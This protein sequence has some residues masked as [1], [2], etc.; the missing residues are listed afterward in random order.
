[1]QAARDFRRVR[2]ISQ[3]EIAGAAAAA[4]HRFFTNF[5]D[6]FEPPR[7]RHGEQAL[8]IEPRDNTAARNKRVVR[9]IA[10]AHEL[11]PAPDPVCCGHCPD[12]SETVRCHRYCPSAA[13]RLSSDQ[14]FPLEPLV[15]PLV[16]E[17]K[18]LGVFYP[19]WSCEGHND[20]E[21]RLNKKP[22]IWFYADSVVHIRALA[23]AIDAMRN[24]GRLALPWQVTVTHSDPDNP[25]VTFSLE[26]AVGTERTLDELQNDL[27][28][29]AD[30][31]AGYFWTAC[32]SL[33]R[34]AR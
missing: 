25:D 30:E 32:D 4:C 11:G 2:I 16:F 1:M 15:A 17:L 5:A 14:R 3:A 12:M 33:A 26:P 21:G 23:G 34:H 13:K 19:C 28:V 6:E 10:R 8:R 9:D 7:P 22:S 27:R 31:I 29:M 18:R 20:A 24:N